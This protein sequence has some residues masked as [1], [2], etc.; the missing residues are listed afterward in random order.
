MSTAIAAIIVILKLVGSRFPNNN[1]ATE[2]IKP[3]N[4]PT[5]LAVVIRCKK[6]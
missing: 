5:F 6:Y 2:I 1:I 4:S 3:V